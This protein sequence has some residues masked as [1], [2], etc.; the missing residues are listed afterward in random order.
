M[1]APKI[2]FDV[3]QECIRD[4]VIPAQP[5]LMLDVRKVYPDIDKIAALIARD[6]A[7]GAAVLKTVNSPLFGIPKKI[8]K[9]EQAV[10]LLGLD[11]VM[12]ILSA[13]LLRKS[14]SNKL[15]PSDL[16]EFWQSA[17]DAAVAISFVARQLKIVS[18]DQAFIVGL[19]HNCAMPLMREKYQDYFTVLNTAYQEHS[20]ALTDLEDERYQANH[21]LIGGYI[22]RAWHLPDNVINAI[23]EHHLPARLGADVD[24]GESD[25]VDILCALLKYAEHITGEYKTLGGDSQDYE[26]EQYHSQ[27]LT[28]LNLSE[29]DAVSL[30]EEATEAVHAADLNFG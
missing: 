7:M 12:N 20:R 5:Q 21:A 23:G 29:D 30:A 4:V 14:L 6:P 27:V 19:F 25:T 26:W 17:N 9:I 13:V 8:V 3:A 1:K 11:S 22:A 10:M 28:R 2:N 18:P 15:D 24:D 16:K